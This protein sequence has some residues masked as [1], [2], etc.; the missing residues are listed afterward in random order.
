MTLTN[1]DTHSP[2]TFHTQA[3]VRINSVMEGM[4]AME[5]GDG[6]QQRAWP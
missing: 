2:V 3:A 6:S 4:D 5:A 1:D